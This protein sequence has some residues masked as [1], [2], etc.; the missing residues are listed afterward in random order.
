MNK[1]FLK[2]FTKYPSKEVSSLLLKCCLILN[3]F[4]IPLILFWY[5][6]EFNNENTYLNIF[7]IIYI[8]IS[9]ILNLIFKK[10]ITKK[11]YIFF[12]Y[13]SGCFLLFSLT[14][15]YISYN[16]VYYQFNSP[17]KIYIIFFSI[18]IYI[19][20][21]ILNFFHIN[22]KLKSDYITEK[23]LNAEYLKLIISLFVILG[24]IISRK[25]NIDSYFWILLMIMSLCTI[26]TF[27]GFYK[28]KLLKKYTKIQEYID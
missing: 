7:L 19:L 22:K 27:N 9:V 26:P 28:F 12:L 24:I 23:K 16:I 17:L 3:I 18:I 14:L 13:T 6:S 5:N 1:I 21:L 15:N 11:P 10:L 20:L 25:I 2:E 4:F 8:F